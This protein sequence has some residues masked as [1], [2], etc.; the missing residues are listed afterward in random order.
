[1][2]LDYYRARYYQP[3]LAR[4]IGEDPIGFRGGDFNL[5]AYV[6]NGP[7]NRSDPTGLSGAACAGSAMFE[8]GSGSL[9]GRKDGF[10]PNSVWEIAQAA[11]D[12]NNCLNACAAGGA[13]WRNFCRGL[14]PGPVRGACWG[15]ELASE[16]ACRGWCFLHWGK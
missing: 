5:Y 3:G 1:M 6:S 11:H 7:T 14:P 9:A 13:A 8:L 10:I 4:F 16:T 12:L 15:L 2:A